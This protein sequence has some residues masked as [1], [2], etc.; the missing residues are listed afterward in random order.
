MSEKTAFNLIGLISLESECKER[1]K[2]EKEQL[3]TCSSTCPQVFWNLVFQLSL[4]S[5]LWV[6]DAGG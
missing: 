2:K 6:R 4:S 3:S 1:L 5:S